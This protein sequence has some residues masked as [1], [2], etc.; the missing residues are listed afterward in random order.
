M[1]LEN[2]N[3][4]IYGTGVGDGAVTRA[5]ARENADDGGHCQRHLRLRVQMS[6]NGII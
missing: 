4:A 1:S 6:P 3:A 5:F 2:K